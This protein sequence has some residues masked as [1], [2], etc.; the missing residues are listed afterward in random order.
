MGT[1]TDTTFDVESPVAWTTGGALGGAIGAAAFGVLAWVFDPDIVAVAIPAIYGLDPTTA[2]GWAIHIV[3]GVALGILFGLLVTR[4]P[5]RAA[6]RMN[7]ETEVISKTGLWLR[8]AGAG[9]V[10]GLAIWAV[11]PLLVLPVWVEAVG[12]SAAEF[13][14]AAV[15]S[16]LGH[17]LFGTVLGLVFALTVDY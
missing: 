5:I 4:K 2:A 9:F 15:E 3:H 7:P 16:L 6:V 12:G 11:L 13:P 8:L 10:F 1:E 14:A 17:L